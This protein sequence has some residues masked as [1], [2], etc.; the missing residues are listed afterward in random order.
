MITICNA[1]PSDIEALLP[2]LKQLVYPTTTVV[3][4]QRFAKFLAT[5]DMVLLL[6]G[7]NLISLYLIKSE[8]TL[9]ELLLIKTTEVKISV[10]N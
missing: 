4:E 3:L 7:L 10:K 5:K 8:S 6:L 1:E 2:L 9:K